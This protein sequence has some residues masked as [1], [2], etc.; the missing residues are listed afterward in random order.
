[1]KITRSTALK[2]LVT[3]IFVALFMFAN[4]YSI[5]QI[6]RYGVELYFYDKM[7]VAYQVGGQQGMEAELKR[8]LDQEKMAIVRKSAEVFKQQIAK[9]DNPSDYLT[10]VTD[11]QK[12]KIKILKHSR[13]V[14]FGLIM[15]ILVWRFISERRL[16]IQQ[17]KK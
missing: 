5:R 3:L 17:S 9:L 12:Q 4:V 8:V 13:S 14:A 16:R 11:Q 1:M 15:L 7:L 2:I 6:N 10:R